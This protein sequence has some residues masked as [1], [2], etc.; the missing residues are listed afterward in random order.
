SVGMKSRIHGDFQIMFSPEVQNEMAKYLGFESCREKYL[1]VLK[2]KIIESAD[3]YFR[4]R[5]LE[6]SFF[7]SAK[8]LAAV[9]QVLKT[10]ETLREQISNLPKEVLRDISNGFPT[11]SDL[12]HGSPSNEDLRKG[13]PNCEARLLDII[14][15]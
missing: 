12:R 5:E 15:K 10:I 13:Y 2:R 1:E 8:K 11:R 14:L 6:N 4:N 3:T 9:S 7:R